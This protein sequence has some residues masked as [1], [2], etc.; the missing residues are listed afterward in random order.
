MIPRPPRST[1]TDTLFPYTTLFRSG[2]IWFT[3]PTYGIMSDYEG[4]KSDPEQPGCYVYRVDPAS[5]D[6][7][8]VADDFVKPNGLAFSPDEKILYIAD[9]GF[10]HDAGGPHHIRAFDVADGRKLT[11]SRIFAEVSPGVPDG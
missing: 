4:R 8:V 7:E 6:V 10:S 11:K 3:D 5:G 2:G 1:R 9:S